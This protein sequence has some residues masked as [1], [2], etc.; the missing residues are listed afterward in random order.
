MIPK[1]SDVHISLCRRLIQKWWPA[2]ENQLV[3]EQQADAVYLK[4]RL[5]PK[6]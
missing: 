1:P 3:D 5:Y 6:A 2:K 4:T